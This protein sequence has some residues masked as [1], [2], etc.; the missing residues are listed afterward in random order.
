M[1]IDTVEHADLPDTDAH[2][3]G[4]VQN[5]DPGAIGAG[6]IWVDTSGGSGNWII[7][8]RNVANT[9]WESA[10]GGGSHPNLA[11]H[12]ALGLATDAELAAHA[13]AADPHAL[14]RLESADHS[15]ASSGLQGGTVAHSALT[16]VTADGHHTENHQSR[17]LTGGGDV[18]A[19]PLTINFLI[20]GGGAVIATGIK[21]DLKVDFACTVTE[22][23]IT[24][25][26]SGS[27]VV[28]IWKDTYANYPPVVG[29]S[30]CGAEKPTISA[31]LKGQ[32][33][34]LNGGA[35]WAIAAGSYLRFN[36]DSV[37][38]CKLVLVALKAVR[39]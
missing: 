23:A 14:Y 29:D 22:W 31:A 8:V 21:G 19:L 16:G 33:T 37:T 5:A 9:G 11:T 27:I 12:D 34:S 20:D 1:A 26:V 24:S 39:S 18:L 2:V 30:M 36:V 3:P 25:D 32:D 6:K 28:D 38:S 7:K 17:H 15:H 10:G 4:P 35:G 13:A